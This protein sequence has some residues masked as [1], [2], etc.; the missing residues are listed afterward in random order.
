M[1]HESETCLRL[2]YLQILTI[3]YLVQEFSREIKRAAMHIKCLAGISG[4]DCFV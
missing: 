4:L 1:I 3:K 2:T